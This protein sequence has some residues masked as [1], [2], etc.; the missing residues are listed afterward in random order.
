MRICIHGAG[1]IGGTMAARLARAGRDVVAVARGA[2][3]EAMRAE[4][5]LF[6]ERP[7]AAPQRI[8]LRCAASAAEAGP[9]DLV[10]C[11]AKAHDLPAMA[12][13]LA[14]ALA[15]DGAVAFAVNGV[16]WWFF[17]GIGGPHEGAVVEA[18]DPGGLLA[19]RLGARRAIG[20]VIHFLAALEAP[21]IVAQ[22]AAGRLVLGEPD[23]T[24]SPRLA[25]ATAAL[26][27]PGWTLEATARIRDEVAGKFMGN[28]TSNPLCALLR[29]P[30]GR[31]FRDP[32]LAAFGERVMVEA[33]A[34][35]LAHGARIAQGVDERLAL[36][37]DGPLA[38]F[39]TSTLLDVDRGRALEIDAL[40][41]AVAEL[42]RRAGVA[43]PSID[44]AYAMVRAMA[45]GTGLYPGAPSPAAAQ[46]VAT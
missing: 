15:P 41:L 14:A 33:R 43:T 35:A 19:R 28:A 40:L 17:H 39:R 34:V 8:A 27:V 12:E 9:F 21:G 3:L 44:L 13:D 20:A 29:V 10:V 42:G 5:L 23:G 24:M 31:V 37:R 38:A 45:E 4:G 16:P 6:R 25:A 30:I 18:V 11:T 7:G 26:D 32:V 1:A 36:Y 2:H 22:H 46:A